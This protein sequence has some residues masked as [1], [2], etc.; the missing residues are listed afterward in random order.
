M[1]ECLEESGLK[2]SKCMRY[3]SLDFSLANTKKKI[4]MWNLGILDGGQGMCL[5][6]VC[7]SAVI[8]SPE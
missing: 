1:E 7:D 6:L 3:L 5:C 8:S 4:K 2:Q